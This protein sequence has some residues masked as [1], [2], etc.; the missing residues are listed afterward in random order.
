MLRRKAL[1][2]LNNKLTEAYQTKNAVN[3]PLEPDYEISFIVKVRAQTI[4]FPKYVL[5]EKM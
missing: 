3:I 2:R 1:N 5:S 4:S